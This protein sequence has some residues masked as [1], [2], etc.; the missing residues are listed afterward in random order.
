MNS[1]TVLHEK[2]TAWAK[3]RPNTKQVPS[4]NARKRHCIVDQLC[5]REIIGRWQGSGVQPQKQTRG[6]VNEGNP[7]LVPIGRNGLKN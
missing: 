4:L 1:D 2:Q 7:K 3:V 5:K 6:A